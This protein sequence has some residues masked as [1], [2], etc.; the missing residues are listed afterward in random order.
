MG[1]IQN[2]GSHWMAFPSVSVPFFVPAFALGKNAKSKMRNC[3]EHDCEE[4]QQSFLV[5]MVKSPDHKKNTLSAARWN[6]SQY[7]NYHSGFACM[8]LGDSQSLPISS[9]MLG[10]L[11]PSNLSTAGMLMLKG[12][13]RLISCI[14]YVV[15]RGELGSNS[16]KL[17]LIR[18]LIWGTQQHP[19]IQC[20]QVLVL[21]TAWW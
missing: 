9:G 11:W 21:I 4:W 19:V 16:I 1:W 8:H 6:Y 5:S 13:T 7:Y 20:C 3:K 2:W 12:K 10:Q 18:W 15:Q 17:N 14:S